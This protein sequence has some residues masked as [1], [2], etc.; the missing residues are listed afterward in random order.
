MAIEDFTFYQQ[1]L[2]RASTGMPDQRTTCVA[3]QGVGGSTLPPTPIDVNL[4][5]RPYDSLSITG[6]IDITLN[7]DINRK[8]FYINFIIKVYLFLSLLLFIKFIYNNYS[9]VKYKIM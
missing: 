1:R 2:E 9:A 8:L 6:N 7:T 3:T 4:N 5:N